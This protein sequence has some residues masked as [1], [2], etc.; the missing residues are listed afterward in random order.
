[1]P[2]LF[3]KQDVIFLWDG[4]V[5]NTHPEGSCSG[6]FCS[7]HNPSEHPLDTAPLNWREDR[8]LMERICPHGIGHPDPDD[9]THKRSRLS[10]ETYKRYAF[11]VHGCDGCCA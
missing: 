2:G 1:M 10:E 8:Y 5:L 3:D 4:R 6:E 11:E 7:V 9:L